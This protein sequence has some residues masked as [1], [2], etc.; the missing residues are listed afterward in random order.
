MCIVSNETLT[1][2]I[3]DFIFR[4]DIKFL[5]INNEAQNKFKHSISA[6][7]KERSYVFL[8]MTVTQATNM[9]LK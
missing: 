4:E 2:F 8:I 9:N 5:I 3:S 7:I 6:V 1:I